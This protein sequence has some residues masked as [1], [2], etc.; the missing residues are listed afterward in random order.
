M[1]SLSLIVK[2]MLWSMIH[3]FKGA[4]HKTSFLKS[5]HVANNTREQI[6]QGIDCE[7]C[8]GNQYTLKILF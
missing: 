7:G 3:K 4:L 6:I 5:E 8:S 1:F 2:A